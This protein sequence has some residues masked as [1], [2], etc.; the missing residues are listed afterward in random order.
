MEAAEM[1]TSRRMS[2]YGMLGNELRMARM[3]KIS[4]R[5]TWKSGIQKTKESIQM[6]WNMAP[7]KRRNP[8][9]LL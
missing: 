8:A 6:M 5:R 7:L 9:R 2:W 1:K 4:K 3:R